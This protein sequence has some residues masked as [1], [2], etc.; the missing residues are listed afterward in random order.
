MR[1]ICALLAGAGILVG[2]GTSEGGCLN[3]GKLLAV[4]D[5]KVGP[6]FPA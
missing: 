4:S 5:K 6:S 2:L 1:G 3:G